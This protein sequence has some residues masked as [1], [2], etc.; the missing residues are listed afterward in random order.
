MLLRLLKGMLLLGAI[1]VVAAMVVGLSGNSSSQSVATP[2]KNPPDGFR[3]IK[4]D[5]PL[6]SAQKLRETALAGCSVVVQQKNFTDT[7]PCSHMHIDT[8]DMELFAQRLNVAPIFGVAISEQLLTWSYRKFWSGQVFVYNYSD[9]DL[10]RLRSALID[11]YGNPTFAQDR[12][13]RWRWPAKKVELQLS[14]DPVPKPSLGSDKT[15]QTSISLLFS[16]ID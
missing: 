9:D 1:S 3:G 10:A 4:W 13:T 5:S 8:D 14:F 2:P 7:P 16:K 6:P 12:L 11:Q 15:R